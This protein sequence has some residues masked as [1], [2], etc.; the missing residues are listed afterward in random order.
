MKIKINDTFFEVKVVSDKKSIQMGMM[1]K[2]FDNTFNGMLFML[3]GSW[4]CFWMKNCIQNLDI[5]IIKNNVI[6][7]IFHNC[8]PCKTDEC[9]SYCGDGNIVLEIGGGECERLNIKHGDELQY[10]P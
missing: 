2:I 3:N 6:N 4:Q 5:I 8:P 9:E 10:L 7:K 1:G